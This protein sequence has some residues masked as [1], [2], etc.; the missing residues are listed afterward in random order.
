LCLYWD[1]FSAPGQGLES[2]CLR[3]ARGGPALDAARRAT[4]FSKGISN[5]I[6]EE[7]ISDSC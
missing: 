7:I 3:P 2:L 5:V 1:K 4:D 6:I